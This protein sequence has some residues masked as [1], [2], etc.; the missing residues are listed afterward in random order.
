MSGGNSN[1]EAWGRGVGDR[2]VTGNA[3]R[4]R[5]TGGG[6]ADAMGAGSWGE[7]GNCGSDSQPGGLGRLAVSDDCGATGTSG[8]FDRVGGSGGIWA[9]MMAQGCDAAGN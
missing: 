4:C 9:G 5:T 6:E 3:A 1:R 2:G 7:A 8:G